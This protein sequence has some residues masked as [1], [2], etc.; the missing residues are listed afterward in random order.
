MNR[1]LLLI[2]L[3]ASTTQG[4]TYRTANFVVDAEDPETACS[5]AFVAEGTRKAV[6]KELTGQDMPDWHSPV[7][8]HARMSAEH[9][10]VTN[11]LK[12][13]SGQVVLQWI[14]LLG[15]T[16]EQIE[17]TTHEVCH[18]VLHRVYGPGVPPKWCDEGFAVRYEAEPAKRGR[19]GSG[20]GRG[21]LPLLF[22]AT[23]YPV[24][25]REF[26]SQSY[27]VTEFLINE[28]S[29]GLFLR[30]VQ[31]APAHGY[32][33]ASQEAFGLGLAEL[34]RRWRAWHGDRF[35]W[36]ATQAA[37]REAGLPG[38]GH[39]PGARQRGRV[40]ASFDAGAD[41]AGPVRPRSDPQADQH[42]Q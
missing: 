4:A 42:R 8:I 23:D 32:E 12:E 17:Y 20:W 16:S 31:R 33:A 34:D 13:P 9:R 35:G 22:D 26:Y 6:S 38:G 39:G 3:I 15:T 25:W 1:L 40:A 7:R 11:T 21:S 18:A 2:I 14:D 37:A 27:S 36:P 24:E 19:D 41:P 10:G 28:Y 5:I 30:F 29:A